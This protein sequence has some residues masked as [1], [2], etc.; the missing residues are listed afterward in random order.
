LSTYAS[1][2]EEYQDPLKN[3]PQLRSYLEDHPSYTWEDHPKTY[4]TSLFAWTRYP[5]NRA[6]LKKQPDLLPKL[7]KALRT[8]SNEDTYLPTD[9]DENLWDSQL[10]EATFERQYIPLELL[11]V[12]SYAPIFTESE[13]A[14]HQSPVPRPFIERNSTS[15]LEI[16]YLIDQLEHFTMD[17][18]TSEQLASSSYAPGAQATQTMANSQTVD[19]INPT[20]PLDIQQQLREMIQNKQRMQERINFL[21]RVG[22]GSDE[23]ISKPQLY[24]GTPAKLDTFI[25]QLENYFYFRGKDLTEIDKVIYASTFLEK[26]ALQTFLPHKELY[27]NDIINCP[28][29]TRLIMTSLK[30]FIHFLR[31][32][33]GYENKQQ[34]A[35]NKVTQ[36]QQKGSA[37]SYFQIFNQYAPLT[38]W[39]EDTLTYHAEKGLKREVQIE[40]VKARQL[41]T[42]SRL[43]MQVYATTSTTAVG[44]KATRR[45][46]PLATEL[47][48]PTKLNIGSLAAP[49]GK[50]KGTEL[51]QNRHL[52]RNVCS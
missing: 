46:L 34:D 21:E 49:T 25:N 3:L 23:K 9:F 22:T 14:S 28:A 4:R 18:S 5:S 48:E 30:E 51:R 29:D 44:R 42:M 6:I 1:D 13:N 27:R 2:D 45:E 33:V 41:Q 19:N 47:P 26:V 11:E 39:D 32:Q 24:D 7:Y 37:R 38:G 20:L 15:F 40:I 16:N 8:R 52:A 50:R 12:P 31:A 36:L 17:E 43:Q 35:Q 10:T